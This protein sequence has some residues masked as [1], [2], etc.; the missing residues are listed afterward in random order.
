ME[1]KFR[2]GEYEGRSWGGKIADNSFSKALHNLAV[3]RGYESQSAL[4]RALHGRLGNS[5]VY[6]WYSGR[7]VPSADSFGALLILLKPNDEELETLVSFY[8][9]SLEEGRGK[10]GLI[11]ESSSAVRAGLKNMHGAETAFGRW[12]ER[13]CRENEVSL[14][15]VGKLL[16]SINHLR[17]Q[18]RDRLSLEAFGEI[19][20]NGPEALKLSPVEADSLTEAIVQT[21][22]ERISKGHRFTT[23]LKGTQ[24]RALQRTLI[25]KTYNGQEAAD[26]LGV[27][28]EAIRIKRRGLGLPLLLTDDDLNL[29]KGSLRGTKVRVA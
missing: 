7:S 4:A 17:R 27:T 8:G 28:R 1:R 24:L 3:S 21:I 22:Q 20:Q 2:S 25:C 18:S 14:R 29:I 19:L 9:R 15:K 10:Q 5:P 6:R 26:R 11:A 16:G 12:L 13:F 23:G